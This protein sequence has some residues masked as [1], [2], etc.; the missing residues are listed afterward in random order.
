MMKA[1]ASA[2][3]RDKSGRGKALGQPSL[4]EFVAQRDYTGMKLFIIIFTF[5]SLFIFSYVMIW[6]K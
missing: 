2:N 4:E 3:N 5:Y 1:A 6:N